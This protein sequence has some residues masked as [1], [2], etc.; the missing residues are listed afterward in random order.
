MIIKLFDP[1]WDDPD[2]PFGPL[3]RKYSPMPEEHPDEE[4]WDAPGED[5]EWFPQPGD[6]KIA[7]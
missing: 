4:D 2:G 3:I 6:F 1:D 7:A 5:Q